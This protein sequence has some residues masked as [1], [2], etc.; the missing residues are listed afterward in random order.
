[1]VSKELWN[2]F[3]KF[4]VTRLSEGEDGNQQTI[5]INKNIFWRKR[6]V[7]FCNDNNLKDV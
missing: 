2:H 1:M 6:C 7:L 5:A 4:F 3:Y